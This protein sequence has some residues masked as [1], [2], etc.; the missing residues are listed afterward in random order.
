MKRIISLALVCLMLMA[1]LAPAAL[2]EEPETLHIRSV[3][4]LE[5]LALDCTLD[6]YSVGLTVVL[7][8]DL[9]LD[10]RPLRSI[11]T[12][13]GVF[14]GQ[15]HTLSNLT[16]STDGSHQGLFR[17]VQADGEVKNLNVQ[18]VVEPDSSRC[19]VG[20]IVGTNYGRIAD[21]SFAGT[22]SGL[23]YVGGIAGENYGVISG[24]TMNG[25]VS[26]KRFTG[27]IAG[28]SDHYVEKCR[29]N[30]QVNT[31]ISA[32]GIQFDSLTLNT[33]TGMSLTGAEDTDVVSDS[34]G[35][36]GY[37]TGIIADC[38]NYGEIGYP[39]YGYNVG[40]VSG[41]HSGH[42]TGCFNF[43][44]VC[45]RKDVAGIVGQMEPYL[46]LKDSE[47]LA[48]EIL[49]LQSMV[50]SAL[51]N[52]SAQS[53]EITLALYNI[54][55]SAYMAAD[56][57][58]WEDP[59]AST[60]GGTTGGGTTG[61][62]TTGGGTTGT[63]T[64]L[65]I[66]QGQ[67]VKLAA[68]RRGPTFKKLSSVPGSGTVESAAQRASQVINSNTNNDALKADL[69]QMTD[70]MRYLSQAMDG[71]SA[72]LTGDLS[73]V[74]A[75]LG[76]VMLMMSRALSGETLKNIYQDVSADAPAES[77]DGRVSRCENYGAV[78]GDTNV[79]GVAGD[80]GIEYE[81]DLEN[82]VMSFVATSD[83]ITTTY[84]SKCIASNN[85][86][87]GSIV[88]KKDHVG[89]IAGQSQVGIVE[90]CEGYGSV[91]STEGGYVG[92]IVG[93]SMTTVRDSYAMCQLDGQEYVGGI[94]GFGATI[95]GCSSIIGVV[96]VTACCG[97]I[98]GY[99]DVSDGESV[100]NNTYVSSDMGAVDGISYAGRA[101]A[102]GYKTM[103]ETEGIPASFG[104]LTL[105]FMADGKTV[106]QIP[107]EYGGSIDR[108]ELPQ[109]PEK[110]GFNGRWSDYDY[111]KLYFSDTV[112]AVY[113]S[114]EGAIY[115]DRYR[116]GST[117]PIVLV[118]GEFGERARILLNENT[119]AGYETARG[120]M[121]ENWVLS[122]DGGTGDGI[123]T[124]HYLEPERQYRR[125][126]IELYSCEDG[127]WTR[128]ETTVNGS[129]LIFD[130]SGD[131]LI[132]CAVESELEGI[133]DVTV[134]VS[135]VVVAAS[136]LVLIYLALRKKRSG[137]DTPD[138]D[139][140]KSADAP[141]DDAAAKDDEAPKDDGA[142]ES[143]A[144]KPEEKSEDGEQA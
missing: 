76:K 62:G 10:G 99:A 15:G 138:D 74:S 35:V 122:I 80:M 60:G 97:A 11:P 114:S 16:L 3:R 112:E 51:A 88:G 25:R 66:R 46:L 47:S 142:P 132:F 117:L 131:S 105:T 4:D 31:G 8:R 133:K 128:L 56:D 90:L 104:S 78:S 32:G 73:G 98:A 103:L 72:A 21:C 91:S 134:I 96:S 68:L 13:S 106:A 54:A 94:A 75:Q 113:S 119:G 52:L 120:R 64:A 65:V 123:Y 18:G 39:H 58:L 77:I 50:N 135:A 109:V 129:Y 41:R 7:D 48:G 71:T 86:N 108:A 49:I 44:Q 20:G 92:G 2:A 125:S 14:D 116:E 40:G 17:Y 12:F 127:Q 28:F 140:A 110:D 115:A 124:V 81:F 57:M 53:E 84:E 33:L 24:C 34:G 107:F 69:G 83:I 101:E 43:G 59:N 63:G 89:G 19:Q 87:R 45:G 22:V 136:A 9:D 30:A 42:I 55:D 130:W 139:P 26:G 141:E 126:Q 27:G 61:G 37:S 82:Q 102:V 67:R 5:D 137:G 85:V 23:N 144:P 36:V 93:N 95:Q 100:S 6:V 70:N 1:A 111:T 121:V 29:N 38:V 143:G 118:E 79:G